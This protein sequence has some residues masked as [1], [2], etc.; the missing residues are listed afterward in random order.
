MFFVLSE[1]ENTRKYKNMLLLHMAFVTMSFIKS[2]LISHK[3]IK[4]YIHIVYV[5]PRKMLVTFI[6]YAI[7][8]CIKCNLK[9]M[10]RNN[11]S[12]CC[13]LICI[14]WFK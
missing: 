13:M 5:L 11:T 7:H 1:Y 4:L 8:E 10:R 14:W 12:D 6:G 3:N 2:T 9:F